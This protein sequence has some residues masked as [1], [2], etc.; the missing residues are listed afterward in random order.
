VFAAIGNKYIID[1]QLPPVSYFTLV[2]KVQVATFIMIGIAAI[3][4]VLRGKAE[5]TDRELAVDRLNTFLKYAA[6]ACYLVANVIWF[7]GAMS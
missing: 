6:P 4:S 2:D 5:G 1:S 7:A 3:V